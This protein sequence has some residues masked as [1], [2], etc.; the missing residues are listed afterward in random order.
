MSAIP[1]FPRNDLAALADA[2]AGY[3]ACYPK[4]PPESFDVTGKTPMLSLPATAL[5]TLRY[6]MPTRPAIPRARGVVHDAS[7]KLIRMQADGHRRG[8]YS[9]ALELQEEFFPTGVS[10]WSRGLRY[11]RRVPRKALDVILHT[12]ELSLGGLAWWCE[13]PD[14]DD[15]YRFKTVRLRAAIATL[16]HG[17]PRPASAE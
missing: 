9:I 8:A 3:A 11:V 16:T 6:E 1:I 14:P 7:L 4:L 12:D 17:H 2:A 13:I 15:S 10:G 5:A